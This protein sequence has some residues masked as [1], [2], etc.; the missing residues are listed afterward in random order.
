MLSGGNPETWNGWVHAIAFL[1]IIAMDV[2]APLT[3]SR[4]AWRR[5]LAAN[6]SYVPGSECAVR[7]L[8]DLAVGQRLIP[9]GDRHCLRLDHSGCR[10][11]GDVHLL[12]H[13]V[14]LWPMKVGALTAA[15]LRE[16]GSVMHTRY[17]AQA[18]TWVPSSRTRWAA[19]ACLHQTIHIAGQEP[20]HRD[21]VR[22]PR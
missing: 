5:Q 21:M 11:P 17:V 7:C 3:M 16:T 18:A 8:P 2:L 6:H 10:T 13:A 15:A 12:N 1:L 22:H 9:G 19:Q 14:L 4:G 20:I